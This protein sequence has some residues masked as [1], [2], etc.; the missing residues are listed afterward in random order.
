MLTKDL[1]LRRN[2][3]AMRYMNL[4]FR[5]RAE[6]QCGNPNAYNADLRTAAKWM[7]LATARKRQK[8]SAYGS[9]ARI[10]RCGW[11]QLSTA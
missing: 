2:Y 10:N 8:R 3:D 11:K 6:I 7:D 9:K 5:E 1:K 4:M